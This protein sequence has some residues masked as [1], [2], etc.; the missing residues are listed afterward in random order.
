MKPPQDFKSKIIKGGLFLTIRQIVTTFLSLLSALVIARILGPQVYGI[1]ATS[2]GIFYFFKWTGR[3]G[4]HIYVVRTPDFNKVEIEQILTFYNTVGVGACLLLWLAAPIFGSW[5]GKAE[6]TQIL[7]CLIP[8][9]WLD[10]IGGLSTGLLER[11]LRFA[12]VGLIDAVAQIT[13][14]SVSIP[15]VLVGWGYW[16]PTTG[17]F[18]QFLVFAILS[19]YNAPIK[20]CWRWNWKTVQPALHYG[21]TYYSSNWIFTFKSLTVPLIISR[22]G[23]M[24]VAG[25]TSVSIRIVQQLSLLRQIIGRMSISV[26]AKFI[27]ELS[28]IRRVITKGMAY[29]ALVMAPVCATFSCFSA[30]IIPTFFGEQWL[31]SNQ[32]F[33]LIALAAS[34]GAIFD[35][36]N[37]T[38]YAAGHN[39]EVA[40]RNLGYVGSL[41]LGSLI[42]T[43]MWGVLGYGAAEIFALP[44]YFLIHRSLVNF[45]GSPNYW[46]AFWIILASIPAL[47]GAIWLPPL[48]SFSLLIISYLILL[49]L[50]ES[51][52]S[53]LLELWSMIRKR[54]KLS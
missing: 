33:P 18:L 7:R 52:R 11:E 16:G 46:N 35:L 53:L 44:S 26:M 31:S 8:A 49:V 41:W 22:L 5:T 2:L 28:K 6:V 40:F 37:S 24:E 47:I 15:L 34:V 21:L 50:N 51:V 45:C 30:W 25:I 19:Y 9:I 39:S 20:W 32:L 13:N 43:P 23:G 48:L 17:Y 12:E 38:L 14:Y 42:F 36:H 3:I 29:Q 1:V 10:M 27:T 4:M 54:K